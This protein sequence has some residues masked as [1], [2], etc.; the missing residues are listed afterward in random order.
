MRCCARRPWLPRH[1]R[2]GWLVVRYALLCGWGSGGCVIQRVVGCC[3]IPQHVRLHPHIKIGHEQHQHKQYKQQTQTPLVHAHPTTHYMHHP[4]RIPHIPLPSSPNPKPVDAC[5][6]PALCML[7]IHARR[8]RAHSSTRRTWRRCRPASCSSRR[9]P[10][11]CSSFAAALSFACR[12]RR[13]SRRGPAAPASDMR[14][15]QR[16]LRS[17]CSRM[18]SVWY[19]CACG[20]G[21]GV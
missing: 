2:G 16:A 10:L 17:C 1:V 15:G 19:S 14:R 3:G 9:A 13:A 12:S 18:T 8:G 4:P 11:A 7:R 20:W 5:R 6:S 21:G